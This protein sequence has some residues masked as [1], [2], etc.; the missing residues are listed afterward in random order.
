VALH[1][2]LK[3]YLKMGVCSRQ[4]Y[5]KKRALERAGLDQSM[6]LACQLKPVA[7]LSV[8]LLMNPETDFG[9]VGKAQELSGKEQ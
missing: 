9:V 3:F 5:T 2:G 7:N 1:A 8:T 4:A 6:R